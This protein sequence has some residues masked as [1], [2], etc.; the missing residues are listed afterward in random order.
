MSIIPAL[1]RARQPSLFTRLFRPSL[2]EAASDVL[3]H[4]MGAAP[5]PANDAAGDRARILE[6]RVARAARRDNRMR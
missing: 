3:A 4:H 5:S 1:P 2:S 6:R